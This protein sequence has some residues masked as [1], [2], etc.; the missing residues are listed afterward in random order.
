MTVRLFFKMLGAALLWFAIAFPCVFVAGE[1][2]AVILAGIAAGWITIGMWRR[3]PKQRPNDEN[4]RR[5]NSATP[6][7][8]ASVS[9]NGAG[10]DNWLFGSSV[11]TDTPNFDHRMAAA[12][13]ANDEG[14]TGAALRN[15]AGAGPAFL[16]DAAHNIRH[17]E[18]NPELKAKK[19]AL[20][21][22]HEGKRRERQE[23][24]E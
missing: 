8:A 21:A 7:E 16:R 4:T 18:D 20:I 13:A 11:Q 1:G 9:S 10:Q 17:W 6:A 22:K 5:H 23:V 19:E 14:H 24:A 12:I 2:S 3:R 15:L